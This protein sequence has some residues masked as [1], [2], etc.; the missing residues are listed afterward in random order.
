[1]SEEK[2]QQQPPQESIKDITAEQLE[3]TFR[4][5]IFSFFFMTK[6]A[7]DHLSEGS[8]IINTTSVTAYQGS[9]MLLDYSSTNNDAYMRDFHLIIPTDCV[10]S[11]HEADNCHALKQMKDV[12]KADIRPSTEL[13]WAEL[14]QYARSAAAD[15][16]VEPQTPEFAEGKSN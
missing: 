9:P 13:D 6:A 8:T 2:S 10:A 15:Q 4:T 7:L 11:A 5:N 16:T 3:R 12:L 14:K 1:M